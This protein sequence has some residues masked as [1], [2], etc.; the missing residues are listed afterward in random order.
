MEVTIDQAIEK[1]DGLL[2]ALEN[3]MP[4]ISEEI[5]TNALALVVNR[6]QG[7]G[8][9]G[10]TYSTNK[11]PAFLFLLGG[12]K[13]LDTEKTR[14]F[15]RKKAKKNEETN[16]SEIRDAHG[17]QNRF[18]DLTFTGRM[19]QNTQVLDTKQVGNNYITIIGGMD[20]EVKDKLK[21]NAARYGD[22]LAVNEEEQKIL[23][24]IFENRLT[25]ILSKFL[26]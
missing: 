3:G 9:A 7:E 15:A 26:N 4:V 14:A 6:I 20:K 5:A 22:F 21:W 16:W 1:I 19:W 12:G 8:I 11:V 2:A 23:A 17:N 25:E 13:A 18:V 10:K 24:E